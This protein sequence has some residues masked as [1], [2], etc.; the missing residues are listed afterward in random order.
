MRQEN[1]VSVVV[2]SKCSLTPLNYE[3]HFH[4]PTQLGNLRLYI[5]FHLEILGHIAAHA[6]LEGASV[7]GQGRFWV[8]V[9]LLS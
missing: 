9:Q 1:N 8:K 2:V 6:S 4:R 3:M 5:G 7:M